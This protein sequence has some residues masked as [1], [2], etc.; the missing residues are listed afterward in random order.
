MKGLAQVVK[1][2][3]EADG[4][5]IMH[6]ASSCVSMARAEWNCEL[7]QGL[8]AIQLYFYSYS[9]FQF[10]FQPSGT[11]KSSYPFRVKI[12]QKA[13]TLLGGRFCVPGAVPQL[14][15]CTPDSSANS[16]RVCICK[17]QPP[18]MSTKKAVHRSTR[19]ACLAFPVSQTWITGISKCFMCTSM[20]SWPFYNDVSLPSQQ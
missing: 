3:L 16:L 11:V 12:W 7:L 9:C 1:L 20:G 8:Q 2:D 13:L 19:D 17:C 18:G 15:F 5:F 6:C 4:P 10:C 14:A